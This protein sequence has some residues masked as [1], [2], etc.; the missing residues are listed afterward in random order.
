MSSVLAIDHG[1]STGYAFFED[2]KFI[3]GG[4]LRL[5]DVTK[6]GEAYDTYKPL[7]M[8]YKPD[9]VVLEKVNVGGI[10]FGAMNVIK[11]AQLQAILRLLC[12]EFNIEPFEVNPTSM[13]KELTGNGRAEKGDVALALT[14]IW[15]VSLDDIVIPVYYKKKEGI[16]EL[17]YDKS[18]AVAL[19]TYYL[20]TNK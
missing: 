18:D 13:K 7:F 1:T 5:Q 19:G 12:Y 10:R 20:L 9:M 6:L 8:L 2:D 15:E 16:K 11:L 4:I 14:N 17:I 3:E